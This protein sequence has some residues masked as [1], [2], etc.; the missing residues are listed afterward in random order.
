MSY[1][2][3]KL[4]IV[5][6]SASDANQL[7]ADL[8]S[9]G[10]QVICKHVNSLSSFQSALSGSSWDAIISEYS[11]VGFNAEHLLDLLRAGFQAIPFIVYT[12][13]TDEQVALSVI[14]NGAR[15]C[16]QKGHS[17]RL[18]L[19]INREL[20]YMDLMRRKRQADSHVYR[21]TYHDELTGLP[22]RTLF[23]EKVSFLLTDSSRKDGTIAA[24]Y[25]VEVN[26]L[27]RI[28]STYGFAIGDILIQQLANR[29]SVYVGRDCI[30]T[31]IDGSKF[32]IF[33]AGLPS[34]H[35]VQIFANQIL[36]LVATPFTINNLELYLTLNMGIC[37]YPED[38]K[39]IETL[40]ANA[41]NTLSFNRETWRNTYKFYAKEIGEASSQKMNLELSLRR[42]VDNKELVL[43]Y[44][45][46]IDLRSGE[47][48]AAE[49][50][51]RWNHPEFGLL[52]PEKFI[53]IADETGYIIEIGKWVLYE[54]C[55]QAKS[56]HDNGYKSISIAVNISAIEL[57]QTQLINHVAGVLHTTGLDPNRLELE[58]TESVLMHDAE[59]SIRT[60]HELK[61]MGIR[62]AVDD[63]GTGYSSLSYLR[64]LPI[65]SIKIDRSF[66]KDMASNSDSA[67]IV[68]AIIAL[69]RSL[70]LT[71]QAEG[72]E[73]QEQIEFLHKVNCH[74][75][76]G[77]L[78]NHPVS[79]ESF[80][81]LI[82]QR[83]TGTFS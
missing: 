28:N 77:C 73:T 17:T 18:M 59:T 42:A 54:A 22:K 46:V 27:P 13:M 5:D 10:K 63:F 75:A 52:L 67:A 81:S 39:K 7:C 26:R 21:M 78:L 31:R 71:I 60:L 57:D 62:I 23:C 29:L 34:V 19:V 16:V 83:R 76:Q 65:N 36:R 80:L 69:A 48:V 82:E 79:A 58:I 3:L 49:A 32:A 66:A 6:H 8:A 45:P 64:R 70:N 12:S 72:I 2:N 33:H 38:G 24:V 41:E 14:R 11:M 30:L 47:I 61:Q 50:L 25:F 35:Q 9:N 15:D 68:T 44:Q 74:H 40:L 56:W 53:P 37:V 1:K 20:E 55:R 43:H 4:L 51:V